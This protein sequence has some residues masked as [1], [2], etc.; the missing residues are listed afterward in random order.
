MFVDANRSK[1]GLRGCFVREEV[2]GFLLPPLAD[3]SARHCWRKDSNSG[4][5]SSMI[6]EDLYV[7]SKEKMKGVFKEI[8]RNI[9]LLKLFN[10]V[11]SLIILTP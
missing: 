8:E 4:F 6:L 2:S 1:A 9:V 3:T 5:D 7:S 11:M 10:S